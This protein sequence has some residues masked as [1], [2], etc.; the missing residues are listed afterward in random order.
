MP[1]S[2]ILPS[3]G[4]T[5]AANS[6][7]EAEERE[8]RV[9]FRAINHALRDQLESF[10]NQGAGRT[11]L[12][13]GK[14]L[15]FPDGTAV[16]KYLGDKYDRDP[17]DIEKRLADLFQAE[18][19]KLLN[20]AG[21][22][23]ETSVVRQFAAFANAVRRSNSVGVFH[24]DAGLGK[25]TSIVDYVGKNPL[26][27]ALTANAIQ[28]DAKGLKQLLWESVSKSGYITNQSRWSFLV[29]RFKGSG[30]PIIIDN[31]QRLIGSGRDFAFDFRDATG[32]PLILSGNPSILTRIAGNDQQFS[33]TLMEHEATLKDIDAIA[34]QIIDAHTPHGAEIY[35][36]ALAV[37]K[38]KGGGYLRALVLALAAMREFEKPGTS[39]RE[40]F[41]SAL[42]KNVHHKH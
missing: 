35:D 15:G 36:L 28:N 30:R 27:V 14:M 16:S 8:G 7:P 40:A 37:A 31:A 4:R 6:H 5:H 2:T 12:E 13:L 32:C 24:S 38:R 26:A 1:A 23:I 18:E 25:T 19:R 17:A 29:E 21:E 10:K 33:R 22:V 42:A 9:K 34:R 39:A 11:N 41:E 20:V 3:R